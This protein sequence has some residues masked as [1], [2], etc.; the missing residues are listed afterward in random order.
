[1]IVKT[2]ILLSSIL[3][4]VMVVSLSTSEAQVAS[5]PSVKTLKVVNNY[6]DSGR[7]DTDP[8]V[9]NFNYIFEACAGNKAIRAPQVLVSS[10]SEVKSVK[11]GQMLGANSCT[12]SVT[13]I[14]ASDKASVKAQMLNKGDLSKIVI[15]LESKVSKLKASI[16]GENAK[17]KTLTMESPEPTDF[18]KK[19]QTIT[20][21][22]VDF[23]KDLK[24]ARAEYYRTLYVLHS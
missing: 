6:G 4:I 8:R 15:D 22:I 19:L 2:A 13:K 11:L 21:N 16:S 12:V 24:D 3:A 5:S 10:D 23:R 20:D 9:I 17:L 18:K 14:H 1:M 7:L